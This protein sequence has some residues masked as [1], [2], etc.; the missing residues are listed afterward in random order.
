MFVCEKNYANYGFFMLNI[1]QEIIWN[2]CFIHKGRF[3]IYLYSKEYI[4]NCMWHY[5]WYLCSCIFQSLMKDSSQL[6]V[7]VDIWSR[8]FWKVLFMPSLSDAWYDV[9]CYLR[10]D[11]FHVILKGICCRKKTGPNSDLQLSCSLLFVDSY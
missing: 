8:S 4:R 3:N 10:I 6:S 11:L 2:I 9:L 7:N 5:Y 1:F